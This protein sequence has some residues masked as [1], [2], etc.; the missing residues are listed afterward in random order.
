[1]CG[2][3][4]L[5]RAT[6]RSGRDRD[7]ETRRAQST[8]IRCT[9][10]SKTDLLVRPCDIHER[11]PRAWRDAGVGFRLRQESAWLDFGEKSGAV[12]HPLAPLYWRGGCSLEDVVEMPPFLAWK[13]A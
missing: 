3:I 8:A 12:R 10:D 9:A 13:D 11:R 4:A 7:A 1:M 5:P 6:F 2:A